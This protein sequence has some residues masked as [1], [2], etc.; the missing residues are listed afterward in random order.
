VENR[1][2]KKEKRSLELLLN[3]NKQRDGGWNQGGGGMNGWGKVKRKEEK[4]IDEWGPS[5]GQSMFMGGDEG[6]VKLPHKISNSNFGIVV[7]GGLGSHR[8]RE[9]RESKGS[10]SSKCA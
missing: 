9:T 8:G 5:E 4:A 1:K 7:V 2:D 6:K 10:K 3:D